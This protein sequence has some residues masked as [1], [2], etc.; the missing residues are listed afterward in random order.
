LAQAEAAILAAPPPARG[1]AAAPWDHR[2]G[3]ARL[4]LISRRFG[5]DDDEQRRLQR[6]GLVAAARLAQPSYAWAYHDIY[7]SQLPVYI[8]PDSI[9]QALLAAQD[10]LLSDI[11]RR[12]LQPRLAALLTALHCQ[13]P[14]AARA[15]PA[16]VARDLDVYL[17][18]ARSLLGH[19]V[20]SALGD[21]TV[22]RE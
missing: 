18:V 8:T 3:L 11:E 4:A 6:D 14:V 9:F 1:A 10:S 2:S 21:A 15:L 22:D 16:D 5:L 20:S 12:E 19:R 7:Q 17:V 13:L